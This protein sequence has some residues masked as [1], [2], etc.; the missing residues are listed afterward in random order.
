MAPNE[1]RAAILVAVD[2]EHLPQRLVAIEWHRPLRPDQFLQ[3]SVVARLGQLDVLE[4][5]LEVVSELLLPIP[6]VVVPPHRDTAEHPVAVPQ[7]LLRDDVERFQSI[8]LAVQT[9]ESTTIKLVGR[10]ISNQRASWTPSWRRSLIC[11][12]PLPGPR[13]G[14]TFVQGP[15]R[16]TSWS[17]G[18]PLI[19]GDVVARKSESSGQEL[20][21]RLDVREVTDPSAGSRAG[22][23]RWPRGQRGRGRPG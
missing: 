21:G 3:H 14:R 12:P 19:P 2:Q 6:G 7:P 4:V 9:S 22:C 11:L 16:R 17:V 5:R 15:T 1:D 13:S 8:G 10:S 18:A 20:H 23:R